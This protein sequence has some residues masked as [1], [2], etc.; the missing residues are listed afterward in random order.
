MQNLHAHKSS[1][2]KVLLL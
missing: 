1:Y 2:I